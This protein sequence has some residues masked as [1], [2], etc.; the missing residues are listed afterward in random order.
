MNLIFL[1]SQP[2]AHVNC[3]IIGRERWFRGK[4]DWV[5]ESW[6]G[7][8]PDGTTRPPWLDEQFFHLWETE[9]PEAARDKSRYNLTLV[10][11]DSNDHRYSRKAS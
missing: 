5:R 7:K 6:C 9:G 1:G 10:I 2:P 11:E 8:F 4:D 3:V